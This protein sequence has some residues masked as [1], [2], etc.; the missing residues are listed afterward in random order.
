MLL[1]LNDIELNTGQLP[2]LPK[3]PRFIRDERF[4]ALKRSLTDDPE[5]MEYRELV[6]YPLPDKEGK[7]I[8]IGGNMRLRALKDLGWKEAEAIVLKKDTPMKKLRE[9]LRT[10]NFVVGRFDWD[11]IANDWE[12]IEVKQ[13]GLVFAWE[14]IEALDEHLF[15]PDADS[16]TGGEKSPSASIRV[17]L[18]YGMEKEKEDEARGIILRVI[19][20]YPGT[21]IV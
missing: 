18:P 10:D 14:K 1:Q 13:D 6:V 21:T 19:E 20:K 5:F 3:N 2:G 7:Y 4:E 17:K 12:E 8:I 15:D 11:K 16:G 9:Y